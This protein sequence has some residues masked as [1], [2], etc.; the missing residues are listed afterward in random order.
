MKKTILIFVWLSTFLAGNTQVAIDNSSTISGTNFEDVTE[1]N[2]WKQE[3]VG[4]L[5][6]YVISKEKSKKI[7]LTA[8]STSLRARIRSF[9]DRKKF[10]VITARSSKEAM[11]KIERKLRHKRKLIAN[12][13]FDSHGH[14]GNRYS[15]FTIGEHKF[16]YKNITDTAQTKH[17]KRI[18]LFCD[19][20]TKIGLGSC[21]AG[22][23]FYF[24]ATDSTPASRMNGDSLM[25]GMGT[26]FNQATIYASESWVMAKPG[27]FA[28]KFGFAGYPLQKR[29]LDKVY[30]PVWER[31]GKW[32]MYSTLT[33]EI[34][35]V[36]T[37]ALNRWGDIRLRSRD[38]NTLGKTKRT[39]AEKKRK[40]KTGLAKFDEPAQKESLRFTTTSSL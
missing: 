2:Q 33:G 32:R 20:N 11:H 19:S 28:N 14:Y 24:P 27:I 37:V 25:I 16:S 1:I 31:M 22:A 13:W 40:L 9:F 38:Y 29:F 5:N 26:I 15:C 7:D 4:R 18:A 23:D 35:N 39:I 10:F 34:K 8:L 21:Y 6:F 30:E 12:L 17:L 36:P 3:Q